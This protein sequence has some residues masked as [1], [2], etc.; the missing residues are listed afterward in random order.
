LLPPLPE[1][2]ASPR[3]RGL[4]VASHRAVVHQRLQIT[5]A[6]VLV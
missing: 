1:R 2:I 4:K 6:R 5:R 3:R